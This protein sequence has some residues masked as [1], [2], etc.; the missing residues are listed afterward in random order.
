[1]STEKVLNEL[2]CNPLIS[3]H[4][5]MFMIKCLGKTMPDIQYLVLQV[6]NIFIPNMIPFKGGASLKR[7]FSN[8][9]A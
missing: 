2:L 6:I 9:A 7:T 8:C 3:K 4:A 5:S 1:M